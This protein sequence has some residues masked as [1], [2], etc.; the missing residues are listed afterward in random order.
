[1]GGERPRSGDPVPTRTELVLER[2]EAR[3][4]A[5]RIV[6][7]TA[8]T[9]PPRKSTPGSTGSSP[10]PTSSPGFAW[11]ACPCSSGCSSAST[12][13]LAAAILLA[14]LGATDW[15][16]GF[17]ARRWHQVST[18]GKVL[19]PAGRPDPGGDGGDL[20]DRGGAVPLWFGLAHRGSRELLVSGAV[21]LLAAL[22]AER[23]DVLWVGKAGTFGLMFAYPDLSAGPRHAGWQRPIRD[24]GLGVA[25]VPGWRW[26][27]SPPPSVRRRPG[28][29]GALS[30]DGPG[31]TRGW[32]AGAG[33][34][35]VR[36]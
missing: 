4:A 24:R 18:V 16:D 5:A 22:G 21:L 11:R 15:V 25:A 29:G 13:R 7:C 34:P 35:M 12:V 2:S 14:V 26:P 28:R 10:C 19:D 27:G 6:D 31:G 33:S 1:M 32:P 3:G 9:R 30:R 17:V 20:G 23:I 36:A 8:W